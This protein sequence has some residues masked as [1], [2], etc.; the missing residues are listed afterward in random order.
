MIHIARSLA[1]LTF[2]ALAAACGDDDDNDNGGT[3]PGT[4]PGPGPA[5]STAAV[6]APGDA[7]VF[8]P[9]QVE[10]AR[11]GTV[12]WSFPGPRPHNVSF[13]TAGAPANIPTK[14]TNTNPPG[15]ESRTF[16]TAG[17][18]PYDCTIHP[19]MSGTVVVR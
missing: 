11:G 1:A 7:N 18:F 13:T 12:T 19:G 8:R 6:E 14:P 15:S 17:T 16:A 9:A 3:G 10:V 4:G 5:S 2:A